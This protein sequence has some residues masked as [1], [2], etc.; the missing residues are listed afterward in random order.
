MVVLAKI[1]AEKE[2]SSPLTDFNIDFVDRQTLKTL[3]DQVIDL[4]LILDS[5]LDSIRGIHKQCWRCCQ[6]YCSDKNSECNCKQ[7][8][9]ELEFYIQEVEYHSK[10]SM[11]LRERATTTANLVNLPPTIK[12]SE[13]LI[14]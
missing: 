9:D 7:V 1:G 12:T 8:L 4:Q 13:T 6:N 10:K 2:S 11:K 5:I 14:N 3:E